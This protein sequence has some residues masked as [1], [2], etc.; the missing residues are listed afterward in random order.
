[1]VGPA[2]S[3]PKS[4]K[5]SSVADAAEGRRPDSRGV[6]VAESDAERYWALEF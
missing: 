6:S 4:K 2:V 1:M 5:E 3:R